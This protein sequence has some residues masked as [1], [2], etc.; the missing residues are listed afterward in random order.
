MRIALFT[1]EYPPN[2]YGGAGVH[3]EYLA[4]ELARVDKGVHQVDVLC[5]GQQNETRGNLRVR[6]VAPALRF[7]AQD[8]RHAKLL[9]ALL[10]DLAMVG[11]VESP[12]VVHCHT[13][14]SHLAGCLARPLTGAPLVLTT[15]SL[16]PHRP[17]KVEQLGSAYHA[18]TW[19]ERT[20]YQNADGVV[21]VSRAMKADV[22]SLYGVAANRV[23]VIH[24]GIDPDEYRPRPAP[25]TL[26]RLGVDPDIPIVLFVGRITRQKGIL[27]LVRAIKYLSPGVQVVLCAGA[28]DTEA[29]AA[30]M[31]G[32]VDQARHDTQA[33]IVWIPEMLSK[34]DVI[35]LYTHAEV[36]VCP[37]VYEPFGIINLEAMACETPV[38]AA[39]VGGIPEIVV[40]G[41]TGLL[42]PFEA[43]GGESPEP[44]DADSF[45]RA[46]AGAVNELMASAPRRRAMGQAARSRVLQH[47]SWTHI[48]EVT[49][50][51]Y[52]ELI[53]RRRREA[54]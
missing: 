42:V 30:E 28:P 6:G 33:T 44:R 47:F 18:S 26:R 36:F 49:L 41:E 15:H 21:A 37:S 4:R 53:E 19:I 45:S 40:P 2:V 20:A 13:W 9:D 27:H 32:L 34:P 14:Y 8:P 12:D 17:W 43:E 25:D 22:Q 11:G 54:S 52:R 24:N 39:A 16:E 48:A 50:E 7:A 29:I 35:T 5:F 38:V 1:N 3:V 10:R 46:L 31:A 51:F 23:R